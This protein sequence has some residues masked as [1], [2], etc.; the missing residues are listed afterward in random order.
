LRIFILT[1]PIKNRPIIVFEYLSECLERA[2]TFASK[3]NVVWSSSDIKGKEELQKVLF[4]AGIVYDREIRAF[5]TPEINFIFKVVARLT[6][7]TFYIK[8][9]DYHFFYDQSPLAEREGL[10]PGHYR[11]TYGDPQGGGLQIKY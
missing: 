3:L 7:N 9:G 1:I 4:P 8:K 5:R 10:P 11:V 6:G 2:L